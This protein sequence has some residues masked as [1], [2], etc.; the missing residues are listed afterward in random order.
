MFQSFPGD[1]SPLNR[2]PTCNLVISVD[3]K[4]EEKKFTTAQFENDRD[5]S[6]R[7]FCFCFSRTRSLRASIELKFDQ[8]CFSFF[9]GSRP[10]SAMT[11]TIIYF[12]RKKSSFMKGNSFTRRKFHIDQNPSLDLHEP[13]AVVQEGDDEHLIIWQK[14]SR[15]CTSVVKVHFIMNG[16]SP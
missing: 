2:L 16:K 1:L 9:F 14:F 8:I 5:V 10:M 13:L 12:R 6:N 7:C 4:F 15:R 3:W 11:V